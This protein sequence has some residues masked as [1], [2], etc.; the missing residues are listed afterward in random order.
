MNSLNICNVLFLASQ[1]SKDFSW[2]N[3][4]G[5]EDFYGVKMPEWRVISW[6]W[7][8]P[9]DWTEEQWRFYQMW[10]ERTWDQEEDWASYIETWT[11]GDWDTFKKWMDKEYQ[12]YSKDHM[13]LHQ[14]IFIR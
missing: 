14:D 13:R 10:A 5:L 4:D 3:Y 11:T 7:Q 1:A 2:D 8:K 9:E 12:D 6:V